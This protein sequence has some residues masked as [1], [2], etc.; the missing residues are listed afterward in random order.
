MICE[1]MTLGALAALALLFGGCG[2]P[3]FEFGLL[4]WCGDSLCGWEIESGAIERAGTWHP[5]DPSA[6]LVGEPASLSRTV[7]A[8]LLARGCLRFVSLVAVEDGAELWI[9]FDFDDDGTVEFARTL[10]GPDWDPLY[11]TVN[12]PVA[13]SMLRVRLVK[14]GS[15]GAAVARIDVDA[16]LDP[17]ACV[18]PPLPSGSAH[19]DGGAP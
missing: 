10:D 12:T 8:V 18:G 9:E 4:N 3:V 6:S 17:D 2:E 5:D 16:V 15:A 13:F 11:F 7:P 19:A 14:Y 1:R